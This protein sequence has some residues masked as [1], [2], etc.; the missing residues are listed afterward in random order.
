MKGASHL[1]VIALVGAFSALSLA[2]WLLQSRAPSPSGKDDAAA[3]EG[4]SSGLGGV[5]L[6]M[7]LMGG[8]RGVLA[9]VVWFQA[10]RL[11][12]EGEYTELAQLA[13]YLTHLEP[14][15]PEVWS[16]AA[17]NLAY[18]VSASVPTA[19]E[20]WRWVEAGLALLRDDALRINPGDPLIAKELG[21]FYLTKIGGN[22]D[23]ASPYYR[24]ELA[25]AV[26]GAAASGGWAEIGLDRSLMDD[27]ESAYAISDWKD[28]YAHSI[29]WSALGLGK[30]TGRDRFNLKRQ[31]L[32]AM[33]MRSD[34]D[35]SLR[36]RVL[37]EIL[38]LAAEYPGEGFEE[39]EKA[40]R[41]RMAST[42]GKNM[43]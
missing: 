23:D 26:D 24:E 42:P 43:V 12:D 29:Y 14:H 38:R 4:R 15:T 19:A 6:A 9:E 21:W 16:Y 30:A 37:E 3:V 34:A 27:V 18:N 8:F 11:Q 39:I 13:A 28:P 22:L 41:G 7:A 40:F 5:D 10:D 35:P 31:I 20:R 2:A 25:K 36:E 32:L 17:W 33:I 1:K